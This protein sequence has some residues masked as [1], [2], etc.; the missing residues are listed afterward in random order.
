LPGVPKLARRTQQ[1]TERLPAMVQVSKVNINEQRAA[2]I[3]FKTFLRHAKE[4][5]L[6][7]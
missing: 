3:V 6:T 2:K 4:T 1:K 5:P 7:D